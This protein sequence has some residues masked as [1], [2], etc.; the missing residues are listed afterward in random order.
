MNEVSPK[1]GY[2]LAALN[3]GSWSKEPAMQ[4]AQEQRVQSL[5]QDDPLEKGMATHSINLA[6]RIH[7]LRSLVG[8]SLKE[9]DMTEATEQASTHTPCFWLEAKLCRALLRPSGLWPARL[10]C[11]R[12]FPGKNTAYR[13][14]ISD[15]KEKK[16]DRKM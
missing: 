14:V 3:V 1:G 15:R 11:P 12:D 4:Q 9:S 2:Y 7:G 16:R 10:L 6:W 13:A 5:S 8:C